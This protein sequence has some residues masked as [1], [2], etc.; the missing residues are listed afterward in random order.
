MDDEPSTDLPPPKRRWGIWQWLLL[1][2]P[3]LLVIVGVVVSTAVG[4]GLMT[5]KDEE[6]V[7]SILLGAATVLITGP[8]AFILCI[9]LTSKLVDERRINAFLGLFGIVGINYVIAFVAKL[10]IMNAL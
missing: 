7:L 10:W 4:A 5:G 1:L 9:F 2:T 6:S 8:I 3:S